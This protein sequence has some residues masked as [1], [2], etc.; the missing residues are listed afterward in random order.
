MDFVKNLFWLLLLLAMYFGGFFLVTGFIGMAFYFIYEYV[1]KNTFSKLS[2]FKPENEDDS[3]NVCF[4][5]ALVV[6]IVWLIADGSL[7]KIVEEIKDI[8]V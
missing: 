2:W 1:W 4:S 3:V 7:Q 8:F 6:I 5:C